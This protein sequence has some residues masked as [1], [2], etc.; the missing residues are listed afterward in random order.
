MIRSAGSWLFALM[1]V[2]AGCGR[3]PEG[4]IIAR[5]GDAALTLEDARA[6]VDTTIAPYD[7][8]INVYIGKWVEDEILYQEALDKG[9]QTENEY[10]MQMKEIGRQIAVQNFLRR[11]IYSDTADIRDEAL[12]QYFTEHQ[13]E[14]YVRE[15]MV[16]LNLITFSERRSAVSFVSALYAGTSWTGAVKSAFEDASTADKIISNVEN[17]LY[18]RKTL[19]PTELWRVA[20]VLNLMEVSFPVKTSLGYSVLQALDK[21]KSGNP[22]TLDAVY[23]EVKMRLIIQERRERYNNLINRLRSKHHVEI[24]GITEKETDSAKTPSL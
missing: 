8:K 11:E 20:S 22:A 13:A 6:Q 2:A 15:D 23:D 21:I 19:Y 5:V 18:T 16:R 10:K 7:D 14:F 1:I 12:Q 9:L 24:L 3:Q 4:K 17:R